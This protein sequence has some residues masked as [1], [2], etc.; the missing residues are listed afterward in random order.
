MW[1]HSLVLGVNGVSLVIGTDDEDLIDDLSSWEI[2]ESR[3]VVDFGLRT[4]PAQP[5]VR[6]APRI[7][8]SLKHGSDLLAAT[9][10]VASLRAA[11]LR[12]IHA[13]TSPVPGNLLRIT[14]SVLERSGVAYVFPSGNLSAVSHRSLARQ[15]ITA[16][17]GQTV[18]IDPTLGEVVVDPR[19]GHDEPGRRLAL[20]GWWF[21]HREPEVPT[22]PGEDVARVLGNLASGEHANDPTD[23]ILG[24]VISA[25]TRMRPRYV[26]FGRQALENELTALFGR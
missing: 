7:L 26:A 8:P 15:G 2:D 19:F 18:Q 17:V 23:V 3:S 6:S 22:T 4:R 1:P 21:N 5:E 12:V 10:D 9:E 13:A 25:V 20:A 16:L 14:G 24:L 11:L